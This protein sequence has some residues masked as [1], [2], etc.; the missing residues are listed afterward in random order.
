MNPV[1]I[2]IISGMLRW[3]LGGAIAYLIGKGAITTEQSNF[4][5]SALA[6]GFIFVGVSVVQS[7]IRKRKKLVTALATP[8]AISEKQVEQ[9]IKEGQAPPVSVPKTRA[10]HLEGT[11]NPMVEVTEEKP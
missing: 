5:I 6:T 2:D 1:W 9:M 3:L 7:I 11:P 8:N 4:I 10:P